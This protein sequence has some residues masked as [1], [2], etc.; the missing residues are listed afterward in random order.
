[1]SQVSKYPIKKEIADRIFEI[2]IK[3]LVK[4]KDKEEIESIKKAVER[5]EEAFLAVKP[6]IRPGIRERDV[7]LRIE[8]QLKKRGCKGPAFDIIAASGKNSSMPHARPA[9]KKIE[10][11]YLR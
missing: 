3:T 2:L 11:G 10:K 4:I 6:R 8:E 9:E 7:A 5:A 1:M